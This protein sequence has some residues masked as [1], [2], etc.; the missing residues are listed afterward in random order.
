MISAALIFYVLTIIG[1]FRL[2]WTR[3]N[4]S[5][6]Y[7]CW[8]YPWLPGLYIVGGTT[9]LVFLFCYRTATTW[10]GLVIVLSGMPV[11]WLLRRRAGVAHMRDPSAP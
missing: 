4:T 10:P 5:R 8:G 7:R 3:P 2:R 11:Y 1:L 9:T 6:P